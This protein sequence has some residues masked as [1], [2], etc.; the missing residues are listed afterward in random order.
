MPITEIGLNTNLTN[1]TSINFSSIPQSASDILTQTPINANAFTNHWFTLLILIALWFIAFF[2]FSDRTPFS[3]FKYGDLRALNLSM[4]VCALFGITG[5][6]TALFSSIK[7]VM[8]F[9][10]FF[11]LTWLT[12]L[13]TENKE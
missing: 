1:L 3:E 2:S 10:M 6:E 9:V 5:L 4:G 12:I 7:H 13:A 8:L 11:M